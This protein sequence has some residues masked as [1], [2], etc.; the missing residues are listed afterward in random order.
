MIDGTTPH[1]YSPARHRLDGGLVAHG[2]LERRG[3]WPI[4][5]SV[6]DRLASFVLL[7]LIAPL[8]LLVAA[9]IKLDSPG[10]VLFRQARVGRHGELFTVLKLRTMQDKSS[11]ELHRRYIMA[12]ANGD[13]AGDTG[14][15]KLVNDPRVTRVGAFLR[16]SSLDEL[17]QLINVLR[18]EMSIVGPRPA[19]AYELEF[20]E[21]EHFDRF[22]VRPGLTG[23]W[24]VSGRSEL[25]FLPM[26]ALD[27]KYA[28]TTGPRVDAMILLRTPLTLLRKNA[29]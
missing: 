5:K 12:L 8:L 19:L 26:L 1:L 9:L 10:P 24:Q 16:R 23:L 25:G 20:Y 27:S 7:I 15:K 29:A 2:A 17:P 28:R 13:P 21:P 6:G 18:G 14:L 4:V 11:A 3:A 22:D